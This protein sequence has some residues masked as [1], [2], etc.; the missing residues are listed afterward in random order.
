MVAG[1]PAASPLL[2]HPLAADAGGDQ[3]HA[4]GKHWKSKNDPE[5]QILADWVRGK[6]LNVTN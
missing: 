2:I 5:W 6:K 4:G 3:F 1:D